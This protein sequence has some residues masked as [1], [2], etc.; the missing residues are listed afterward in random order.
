MWVAHFAPALIL[1]RFAPST[2][3]TLLALAGVLPDFLFFINVLLGLEEIK[4]RPH[5]GCFPY[6]CNYPFTHSLLGEAVLGTGFGL[7]AMTLLE[8]PISSFIAIFLAAVSHWP[9]DVLVHRKDVSLAPGDHPT[10]FGLSLFDSSVAVFVIDL[11][12]I[13]AALYFH[14]LTTRSLNPGKSQKVYLIWVLVFTAVQANFSF[15][16][17]PT[18]NARFVHAPI[19]AGQLL[20]LSIGMKYFDKW[21]KPKTGPI[22]KDL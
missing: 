21:T 8:L 17:A 10:L 13:L 12:M 11:A 9:L 14:A 16:S 3:I 15:M 7:I 4:Y 22:K 20:S 1:K 5:E 19:F 2:P 6:E 18:E